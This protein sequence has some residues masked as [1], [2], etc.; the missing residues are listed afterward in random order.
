MSGEKYISTSSGCQS[1]LLHLKTGERNIGLFEFWGNVLGNYEYLNRGETSI[2]IWSLQTA[3]NCSLF[4]SLYFISVHI[5]HIG[6][7]TVQINL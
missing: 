5:F 2:R 6:T 1:V 3:A 4:L 7:Y